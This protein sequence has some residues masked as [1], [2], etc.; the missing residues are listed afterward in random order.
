LPTIHNLFTVTGKNKP[1]NPILKVFAPN[2]GNSRPFCIRRFSVYYQP[3]TGWDAYP[4]NYR[5]AEV[6][7]LLRAT[8]AGESAA[9]LGLSGAGKSN[10]LG[11]LANTQ[12]TPKHQFLLIDSNRLPDYTH[13]AFLRLMRRALG[14]TQPATPETELDAL[15]AAL[16][17]AL[18]GSSLCF[19]LD[20]SLLDRTGL[21]SGSAS[22]ALFNNLR[23]LRDAHKFQLTF[24]TA[25]RHPL[26]ADTEFA[27]LIHANTLTLGCLSESDSRWNVTRFMERKGLRW[28]QTVIDSLI[29]LSRGYPSLLRAVCEAYA[30]SPSL[31]SLPSH[32]AVQQRAAEFW[33]DTPTPQEVQAAGLT[34]H[35]LLSAGRT[36]EA[37]FDTSQLTAKEHALLNHF[38]A[39]PGQVCEKDDLIRT[40]W[41]EDKAF[42]KGVRD[43][44]LA[45]LI[46]RLRE[47]IEPD[48]ASPQYVV[49]VPGRGYRFNKG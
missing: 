21:I 22:H 34:D 1:F 17:P 7:A 20:L 38:L 35:P 13:A 42:T 46:R 18:T 8:Q 6:T 26:P 44:S 15:D 29:R 33:A 10:L 14:D 31:D 41:P 32:P 5:A 36:L 49:T 19:L 43:D 11:F 25:S 39:H 37:P 12:S 27:E 24:V 45:Q 28:P 3:M 23:A 2:P 30:Q 40:V 16:T 48:P 47:K 9:V 4:S